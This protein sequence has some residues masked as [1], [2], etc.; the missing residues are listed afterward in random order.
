MHKCSYSLKGKWQ[1]LITAL[2]VL[3]WLPSINIVI[4]II[5]IKLYAI[6]PLTGLIDLILSA[7]RT[8]P[9]PKPPTGG[10]YSSKNFNYGSILKYS[11]GPLY[12]LVGNDTSVCLSNGSWSGPK[13][14]C[15][16]SMCTYTIN[17]YKNERYEKLPLP[18]SMYSERVLGVPSQ[19]GTMFSQGILR[20]G[21]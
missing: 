4:I 19:K 1:A 3:K 6:I 10:T 7:V 12:N 18:C 14:T 17:Q 2:H 21:N 11:C 20:N 5:N 8:C 9:E 13:P 15:K 16:P